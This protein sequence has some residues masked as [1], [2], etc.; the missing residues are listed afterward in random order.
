[1][2]SQW[3]KVFMVLSG[4]AAASLGLAASS[5]IG[6][7]MVKKMEQ[8]EVKKET[9]ILAGG[10]FWGMEDILRQHPGVLE[11]EVGYTGGHLDNPRYED[12]KMG[13]TGHAEAIRIVFDSQK[14][15]F[16]KLLELFF[17]MHDPTTLNRQ[18][19]DMGSQYRSAIFYSSDVQRE[20]A[21]KIKAQVNHSGKWKKPIVTEIVP[22]AVFY[23][24]ETYH[25]DYLVKNPG[26]YTC[27]WIRE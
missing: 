11:T 27:H 18:G 16:E 20:S 22:A 21:E 24:A 2:K 12:V 9:A 8:A 23:P 4:L 13:K 1:M 7:K 5:G 17:K 15:S 14:T 26:G 19:N 3:I 10:C 25:Q 6:K